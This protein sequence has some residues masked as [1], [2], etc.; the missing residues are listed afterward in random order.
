ML[1]HT[2]PEVKSTQYRME[3][4]VQPDMEAVAAL[5]HRSQEDLLEAITQSI[6]TQPATDWAKV[7][8][9]GQMRAVP[10]VRQTMNLAQHWVDDGIRVNAVAPGF[11]RTGLTEVAMSI[12]EVMDSEMRHTPMGRPATPADIAGTVLFL[13]TEAASYITGATFAVDGG[14]L[15]V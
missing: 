9:L 14:Y 15:T 10:E 13:C 4:T 12:P 7:S 11:T 2:G 8:N 6:Y 1:W 3:P 5:P